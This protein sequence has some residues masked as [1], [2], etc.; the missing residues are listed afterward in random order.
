M[1]L[2]LTS[3]GLRNQ[4]LIDALIDLAGKPANELNVAFIPTAQNVEPGDKGWLIDQLIR[5]RDIGVQQIDIVDIAAVSQDIW[6]PRIEESNVIFVNGGNTTYLMEQ[7]NA[8]GLGAVI[9]DLLKTRVFV[10][11]SAGSYIATPDLR[12]NS[13]QTDVVLDGLG[14]VDF[15]LQ[16]HLHSPKFPIA[17]TVEVVTE[18]VRSKNCPY[19]V[20]A[21]DDQMAI[22]VDGDTIDIVGEGNYLVFEK[23]Q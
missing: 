6:L 20:F 3:G 18:R 13:D 17:K 22:K 4:T 21:L 15:G 1:K 16:V 10:G 12:F 8:S 23:Q 2:L 19:T 7:V 5:I 11:V 9:R 14:L